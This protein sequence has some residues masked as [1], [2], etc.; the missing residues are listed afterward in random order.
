MTDTLNDSVV[1][2]RT[3]ALRERY[4]DI[5]IERETETVPAD[6]WPEMVDNAREGYV[7]G[8]YAWVVRDSEDAAALSPSHANPSDDRER[9]LMILPRGV[10]DWGLPGGGLEGDESFEDT[11]RREVREETSVECSVTDCWLLRQIT[12]KSAGDDDRRTRSLHAFFDARY[13]SG[14]IAIQSGELNG[15]AWF[16]QFPERMQPANERRAEQWRQG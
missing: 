9:V 5:P 6:D 8:A 10:A 4:G 13:D 16:A 12:W 3:D 7:G 15:A 11:V 2:Q 1:R 14:R